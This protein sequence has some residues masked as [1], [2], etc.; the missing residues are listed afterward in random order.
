MIQSV[1]LLAR[2]NHR[3][4]KV[5]FNTQDACGL[6]VTTRE[7]CENNIRSITPT[8]KNN[9]S[10]PLCLTR[11]YVRVQL[12]QGPYEYYAQSSRWSIENYGFWKEL[13][14]Q[15]VLLTHREGRTTGGNTPYLAMRLIGFPQT[16]NFHVCPVGNWQI[17]VI[18]FFFSNT[19]PEIFVD[20]GMRD[21]ELAYTLAPGESWTLPEVILHKSNSFESSMPELHYYLQKH[22]NKNLAELPVLFNTWFDRFDKLELD[23]MREALQAAKEV[24]CE[25]YVIDAGWF[26]ADAGWSNVGDWREKTDKA[27]FGRM[28]DF[29]DEVRAA[30][31]KFGI[32]MEPERYV[33]ATPVMKAHPEWFI[34][35]ELFNYHRMDLS[36]PEA[37][38][39][40]KDE[41]LRLID[42][43]GLEYIKFD[44]NATLGPDA[45]NKE[46][47]EYQTIFLSILDEIKAE[48]PETVLENCSSGAL[49][50][51]LTTLQHFDVMFPSDN[52]NPFTMV[53]TMRGLWQ[54]Y[55]P[56]RIIR[57]SVMREV[58]EFLAQF[59]PVNTVITPGEATFEE[60]ERVDLESL[61]IANFTGG[62]FSFTGDIASLGP[63]NRALVK[64]YVDLYK[65]RRKFLTTCAGRWLVDTDRIQAFE[66]EKDGNAIVSIMYI[67]R[68]QVA[69]RR[70]Y[71]QALDADA[72]YTVNGE[73]RTGADIMKN[74]FD[75]ELQYT[76]QHIK[77]R[78]AMTILDKE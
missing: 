63:E 46:L 72:Y 62:S 41:I 42:T 2:C 65:S 74:G 11:A 60:Y 36:I 5:P 16:L 4:L 47:N 39:Y 56:G 77:W 17:R 70:L 9:G 27:F 31:L 19:E 57:W 26:G 37:R 10:E 22:L 40:F 48:H 20:L 73:R 35:S 50:S 49:R 78:C 76:N 3:T 52:V 21:E 45:S 58:K 33:P 18:P 7:I 54:R 23:H 6:E 8:L 64:K 13:N 32:W 1:F 53:K 55:L 15:G 59:K 68:D 30:G 24:G 66:M 67:A 44:M 14:D 69:T 43:Y 51:E 25:T 38:K 34:Y 28:K 12:K 29:A 75:V 61:L 71:P